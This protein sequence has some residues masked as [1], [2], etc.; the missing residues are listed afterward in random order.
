[1]KNL[2]K[3]SENV[4]IENVATENEV[5]KAEKVLTL[6]EG[7]KLVAEN[8]KKSDFN[9]HTEMIC[10]GILSLKDKGITSYTT[11]QLENEVM[12]LFKGFKNQPRF[13]SKKLED[14]LVEKADK[15]QVST[16]KFA[17]IFGYWKPVLKRNNWI[18]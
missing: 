12:G 9:I 5:K 14:F 8:G 10:I 18:S 11:S 6:L 7:K 3:N 4:I 17:T 1:M 13:T 16:Q 15:N 2:S